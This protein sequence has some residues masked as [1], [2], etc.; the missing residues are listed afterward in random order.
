VYGAWHRMRRPLAAA[1][2]R[3]IAQQRPDLG[4]YGSLEVVLL[5]PLIRT[6]LRKLVAEVHGRPDRR[7]SFTP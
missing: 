1:E 4:L 6:W 5:R 7:K 2:A 3:N